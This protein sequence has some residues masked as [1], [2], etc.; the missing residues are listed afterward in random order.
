MRINPS[1]NQSETALALRA[2]M[3]AT[4]RSQ[5]AVAKSLG[6]T[7]GVVSAYLTGTYKGDIEGTEEKIRQF[8]QVEEERQANPS[9]DAGIVETSVYLTITNALATT[10]RKLDLAVFTGAS[11]IG[12][13]TTL[14]EY[15][16][17]HKSAILIEAD[18]GYTP[19]ALFCELCRALSLPSKGSLHDLMTRVVDKLQGSGR[20][21]IIDE[22]EQLKPKVLDL[23]RRVHD[24][25]KVPI[26]LVGLDTLR[27]NLQGDRM[28]FTYLWSRCG[29]VRKMDLLNASDE[30]RI[31][32]SH[33][34]NIGDAVID[35]LRSHSLGNARTLVKLL[36]WCQ[37]LCRINKVDMDVD[38]VRKA[39]DLIRIDV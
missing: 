16:R 6:V 18:P 1:Q 13:T 38:V 35:E 5:A 2:F 10:S 19:T 14:T 28:S 32:Q 24:K 37:D 3:A 9:G 15:V 30:R 22:A 26:A 21:I 36:G 34:G 27:A 33:L 8:L 17:T 23:I 11:G 31:M 12:K 20:L 7:A 39:I 29:F 4:G 25:A